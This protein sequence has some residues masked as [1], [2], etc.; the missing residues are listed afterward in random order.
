MSLQGDFYTG[1]SSTAVVGEGL[2]YFT[3]EGERA[4]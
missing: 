1:P 2:F 3:R 4:T